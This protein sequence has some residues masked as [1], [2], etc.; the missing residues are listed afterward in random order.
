[1]SAACP[2]CGSGLAVALPAASV[3][4]CGSWPYGVDRKGRVVIPLDYLRVLGPAL[5]LIDDTLHLGRL[6]LR[7]DDGRSGARVYRV[8][9][10]QTNGRITLP[11][12]CRQHL[13]VCY[14]DEL[15]VSGHGSE[16]WIERAEG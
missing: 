12:T 3:G 1:M 13:G 11:V 10:C 14:P 9:A 8:S 4:L 16:V 15:T 7:A 5:I 6:T 2:L